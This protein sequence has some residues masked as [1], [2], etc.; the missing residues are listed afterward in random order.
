MDR[1]G[2]KFEDVLR[3]NTFFLYTPGIVAYP[4][5]EQLLGYHLPRSCRKR[6]VY[7][8]PSRESNLGM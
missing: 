5:F 1:G 8:L 3:S 6:L 7:P 2:N 4:L